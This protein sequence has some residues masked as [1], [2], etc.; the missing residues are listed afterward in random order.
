MSDTPLTSSPPPAYGIRLD[1]GVVPVALK[2]ALEAW[3]GNAVVGVA[4]QPTCTPNA[5]S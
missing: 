1:W 3:L 5:G 2:Q 4:S